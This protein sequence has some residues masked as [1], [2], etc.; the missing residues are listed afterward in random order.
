MYIEIFEEKQNESVSD[1]PSTSDM[2]HKGSIINTK[3]IIPRDNTETPTDHR[4]IADK[5]G[6]S[7]QQQQWFQ[8]MIAETIR[9]NCGSPDHQE[10]QQP[11][12]NPIESSYTSG[13]IKT[14]E[15]GYLYP[16]IPN[17]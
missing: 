7:P 10:K 14:A 13:R 6:F 2:N 3:Y 11:S 15:I 5:T 1:R 8:N 12:P 9:V 17:S 16:D 4:R